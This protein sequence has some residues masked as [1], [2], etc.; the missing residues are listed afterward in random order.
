M[1]ITFLGG[2]NMATALVGGLIAR[3]TDPQALSVIEV[4][5]TARER[6]AARFP[7]RISTAPVAAMLEAD[8]IVLAVKPQDMRSALAAVS[9]EIGSR[10]VISIAAGVRLESLSRW[11]GGHPRIVR[12]MPNMPALIGMG[13][14]GLYAPAGVDPDGRA[15]AEQVLA[16]VGEVVWVDKESLLDPV[17]AV[18]GSGPAYVFWFIEQLAAAG[19]KLGLSPQTAAQLAL[20]TVRGAAEL[21]A[22]ST[23]SP[24]T[25]REQVTS[26]GGTT[27]A[28]LA[29]FADEQMAERFARA[30][31]AACQRG[32]TLGNELDGI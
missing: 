18:S 12:A 16:A 23:V 24:A 21:A 17:T 20:T 2:G 28:A 27:A 11:L 29:V 4:N 25:L 5:D 13:V 26:K 1:K 30:V 22:R 19:E 8:T 9:G 15:R 10:L 14:S 6:F 32:E 31:E 7:V 3:G